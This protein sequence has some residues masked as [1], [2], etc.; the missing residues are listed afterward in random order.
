MSSSHSTHHGLVIVD[1]GTRGEDA[2]RPLAEL[3]ASVAEARPDWLVAHAHMELA[4]PDFASAIDGL[5]ER[6]ADEILVHLHF[7]GEGYHVRET[8]PGLIRDARSRYPKLLIRVSDPLGKDPRI[9][10]IVLDR[11]DELKRR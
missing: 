3:A 6:G 5:V 10:D 8:L 9:T 7:L 1:H 4:E 2:N 11:M